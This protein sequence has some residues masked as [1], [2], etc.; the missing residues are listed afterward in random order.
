MITELLQQW[1]LEGLA[2]GLATFLIIGIF[3]PIVIKSE[4]YF[5][6]RC[7][8][9]FF[10]AGVALCALAMVL[11]SG[12]WSTLAGVAG[13]SSFW[14]I[15]EIYEQQE[16]VRKG[17]FPRNPKRSYPFDS[18]SLTDGEPRTQQPKQLLH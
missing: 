2:A 10:T 8:W 14:S 11:G 18:S 3:H 5:G 4:Y 12:I 7:V 17:W 13:F 15:K 9:V 16:R 1:H 6:T